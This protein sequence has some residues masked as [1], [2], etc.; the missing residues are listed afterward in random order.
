[1]K[2]LLALLVV[3]S[4]ALVLTA[5]EDANEVKESAQKA[6]TSVKEA[7]NDAVA[8]VKSKKDE[9]NSQSINDMVKEAKELAAE[10]TSEGQDNLSDL[11]E[12]SRK[13]ALEAWDESKDEAGE[14][15]EEAKEKLTELQAKIAEAKAKLASK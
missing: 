13:L 5:C 9:W 2:P 14:L 6:Q 12:E 3:V 7:W 10:A 1:M 11:L 4:S 15:S 8:E